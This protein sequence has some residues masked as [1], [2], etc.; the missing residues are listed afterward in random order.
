MLKKFLN[1]DVFFGVS[2]GFALLGLVACG[3]P[4]IKPSPGAGRKPVPDQSRPEKRSPARQTDQAETKN[5]P[6]QFR[7]RASLTLA[8]QAQELISEGR[9]DRA[10]R[11]LERAISIHP[12]G[13]QNYYYLAEAW[14]L[15]KNTEQALHFNELAA[16][17]L[18]GD[19]PEQKRI[20]DQ[21]KRIQ[22][23]AGSRS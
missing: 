2:A 14:L 3:T 5:Q 1:R 19:A 23:M 21:R 7:M 20:A 4:G 9:A 6:A 17:H 13:W 10:I 22:Q 15:K 18:P 11:A 16:L 12:S 8:R